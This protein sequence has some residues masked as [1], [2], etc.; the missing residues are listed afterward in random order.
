MKVLSFDC[1]ALGIPNPHDDFLALGPVIERHARIAFRNRSGQDQDEAVAEA[2]AAAFESYVRLKAR[3]KDPVHEFPTI[4]ATFAV[5]HVKTG[6]HVGGR[7]SSTDV[8]SRKA[9]HKWGFWVEPLPASPGTAFENLYAEVGGQER[10]GA[11][12][13]R[14]WANTQ[15]PVLDQV[16]FRLDWPAFQSTLSRR[17]RELCL[18]LSLGHSA[19]EAARKFKLT[20][21][22]VTQ[23][24]QK[25][26]HE[27]LAFQGETEAA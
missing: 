21:G 7:S 17:D 16:C 11:Y 6:R 25:W 4:M 23:L 15:T 24:R 20:P 13:E 8:L 12:E 1:P 10:Q 22:R 9:Q 5:L 27:W 26:Y 14:L 2:I 3:G 18:F 19:K